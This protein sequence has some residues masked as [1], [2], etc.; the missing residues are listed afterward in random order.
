MRGVIGGGN[1]I[2]DYVKTIDNFPVEEALANIRREYIGSGGAPYNVLLDLAKLG[3]GFPLRAIGRIGDDQAG[4]LI[5]DDCRTYGIDVAGLLEVPGEPTSYTLVTVVESTGKRTFFHQ[6]GANAH[7][8]P[9]DFDFQGENGSHFHYGYVLLL[10]QMDSPDP[11]FGSGAARVL[12]EAKAAGLTTSV[13]LVSEDGDRFG[14]VVP[15][16]LPYADLVFMNEFEATRA[17]GI[18]LVVDGDFRPSRVSEV[19]R[20]LNCTGVLVLHWLQGSAACHPDGSI[21]WQGSVQVPQ[22]EI[23]ATVGSG[24]AFAAGYLLGFMRGWTSAQSLRLGVCCAA[25]CVRGF[26]CTDGVLSE[27]E[28]LA[29]GEKYGYRDC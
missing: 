12:A 16:V 24:D 23:A 22:E 4:R 17:S 3:A 14:K 2:V 10:D 5:L 26:T 1:F 8:L 25:S 15:T 28:C 7:L 29:L 11:D 20:R 21:V 18:D 19:H 13:D 6:R 27:A 9:S